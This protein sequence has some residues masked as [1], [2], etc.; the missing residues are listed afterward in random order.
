MN[1]MSS[2]TLVVAFI[3]VGVLFLYFGGGAMMGGGINGGMNGHA[4]M[5]GNSWGW[6]PA[7]FT[8]GLVILI[9]WLLFRK[10]A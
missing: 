1:K 9:G 10:K 5:G 6:L 8:F 2:R 3:V 4:W 7:L